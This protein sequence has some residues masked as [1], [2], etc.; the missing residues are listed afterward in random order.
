MHLTNYHWGTEL[1]FLKQK[2]KLTLKVRD[3]VNGKQKNMS[4]KTQQFLFKI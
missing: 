4:Y 2:H 3:K 1:K